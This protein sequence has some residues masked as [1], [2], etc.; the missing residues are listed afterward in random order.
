MLSVCTSKILHKYCFY[1][2]LGLI[3]VPRE[4]G[5][6]DKCSS[7]NKRTRRMIVQRDTPNILAI[8]CHMKPSPINSSSTS[9]EM[10][11]EGR[12]GPPFFTTWQ[13]TD[14]TRDGLDALFRKC[15]RKFSSNLENICLKSSNVFKSVSSVTI[16]ANWPVSLPFSPGDVHGLKRRSAAHCLYLRFG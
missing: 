11:T 4:T 3:T 13:G 8:F 14:V 7:S 2:L 6:R 15:W 12:P 9:G 5:N 1:F 10:L 16:L